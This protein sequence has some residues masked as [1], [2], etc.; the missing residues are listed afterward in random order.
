MG[1]DTAD[2]TLKLIGRGVAAWNR[3]KVTSE[4]PRHRSIDDNI[5][6]FIYVSIFTRCDDELDRAGSSEKRVSAKRDNRLHRLEKIYVYTSDETATDLVSWWLKAA[7]VPVCFMN[8]GLPASNNATCQ[9]PT[10]QFLRH[11]HNFSCFIDLIF[12][13]QCLLKTNSSRAR[14]MVSIQLSL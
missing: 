4:T 5:E 2:A 11:L 14:Q 9:R 10:R 8:P 12:Y 7:K 13:L 1:I 3:K 6:S